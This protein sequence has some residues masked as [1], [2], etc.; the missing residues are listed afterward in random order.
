MQGGNLINT[1]EGF[2][3][4]KNKTKQKQRNKHGILQTTFLNAFS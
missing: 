1:I 2:A 3:E 4:N